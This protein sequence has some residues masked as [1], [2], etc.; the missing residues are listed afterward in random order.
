[1]PLHHGRR[2]RRRRHGGDDRRRA[3]TPP[4]RSPAACT[5]PNRLGGNSL[6]DLLVFGRRAGLAAAERALGIAGEVDDR[7]RLRSSDVTQHALSF[8]DHEGGENAYA[9]HQE[10]QDT[11]QD[12][13]GIIRTESELRRGD[14][15]AGR[16]RRAGRRVARSKA[17][18]SSTPAGTSPSTW[19]RCSRSLAARRCRAIER[20]E[21]R[22]GH[23]RDDYPVPD[24]EL[25]N[26]NMITRLTDGEY[27]VTSGAEAASR[28]ARRV[29]RSSSRRSALMAVDTEPGHVGACGAERRTHRDRITHAH[30]ARRRERRRV[31]GLHACR[32]RRARSC[33]TSSTASRPSRRRTSRC[34]GTARPASAARAAPRSTASRASCA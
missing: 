29:W 24:P 32:H 28:D 30:L 14:G 1:M 13:V 9:V 34:A 8:F 5:A 27:V 6:S 17:T 16:V 22:G 31:R 19:S 20:R 21:S 12:L 33:S 23:T 10:L 7:P 3:S 18:V 2:A 15:E 26:V 11:M 25:E 4:A